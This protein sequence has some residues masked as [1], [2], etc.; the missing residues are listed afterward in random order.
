MNEEFFPM[1]WVAAAFFGIAGLAYVAYLLHKLGCV[2]ARRFMRFRYAWVPMVVTIFMVAVGT[3]PILFAFREPLARL[4]FGAVI[5]FTLLQ[6]TIIGYVLTRR[7]LF[8]KEEQ[9]RWRRTDKW[10][11]DWESAHRK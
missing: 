7:T 11:G 5:W 4:C 9:D 10:L 1:A 8:L 6:P 3:L 2:L